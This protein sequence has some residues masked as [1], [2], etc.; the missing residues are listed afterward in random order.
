MLAKP[1]ATGTDSIQRTHNSYKKYR[2]QA[3][4]VHSFRC[5]FKQSL[6]SQL[7]CTNVIAILKLPYKFY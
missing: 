3:S 1:V 6:K 4:I 7:I 5:H 2:T